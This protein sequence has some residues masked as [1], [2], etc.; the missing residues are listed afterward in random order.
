M[1]LTPYLSGLLCRQFREMW[2]ISIIAAY[3]WI[4]LTAMTIKLYHLLYRT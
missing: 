2:I 1:A 4:G 3:H